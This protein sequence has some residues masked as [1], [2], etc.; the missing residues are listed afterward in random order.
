MGNYF[1]ALLLLLRVL[2]PLR[3]ML[4][5]RRVHRFSPPLL[6]PLQ[7]LQQLLLMLHLQRQ[8]VLRHPQFVRYV[9]P[10]LLLL[11]LLLLLLLLLQ[12]AQQIGLWLLGLMSLLL[13]HRRLLPRAHRVRGTLERFEASLA[14][15]R[16]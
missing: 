14:L 9:E 6:K 8:V 3:E 10:P 4:P 13:P 5:T 2:A 12:P 11:V 15:P 7:I 16:R 1:T